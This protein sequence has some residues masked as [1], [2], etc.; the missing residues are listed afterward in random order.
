MYSSV[1]IGK[2]GVKIS[3]VKTL[4]ILH[5]P[6]LYNMYML[7]IKWRLGLLFFCSDSP[8]TCWNGQNCRCTFRLFIAAIDSLHL[9]N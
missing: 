6:Y 1:F 2:W 9:K 4:L 3:K 7:V 5:I 8:H